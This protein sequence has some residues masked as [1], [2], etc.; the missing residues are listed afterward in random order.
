MSDFEQLAEEVKQKLFDLG[1]HKL[2][3]RFWFEY[4]NI[5]I[6]YNEKR[7]ELYDSA[8]REFEFFSSTEIDKLIKQTKRAIKHPAVSIYRDLKRFLEELGFVEYTPGTLSNYVTLTRFIKLIFGY[9]Y[10]NLLINDETGSI[11]W[12]IH[13]KNFKSRLKYVY[14]DAM[15]QGKALE[16]EIRNFLEAQGF[17]LSLASNRIYRDQNKDLELAIYATHFHVRTENL[18]QCVEIGDDYISTLKTLIMFLKS[19]QPVTVLKEV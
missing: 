17:K 18:D 5:Q 11:V 12:T 10:S 14:D 16:S 15:T 13:Y 4:I 3:N 19:D 9:P 8:T 7:F 1:F 6:N 2:D